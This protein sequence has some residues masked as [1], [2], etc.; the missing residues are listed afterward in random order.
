M[1]IS[2]TGEVKKQITWILEEFAQ[3]IEIGLHLCGCWQI[4]V[5]RLFKTEE[6]MLRYNNTAVTHSF[7]QH[8]SC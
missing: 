7:L 1:L 4:A 2:D 6:E 8:S 3:V 5:L